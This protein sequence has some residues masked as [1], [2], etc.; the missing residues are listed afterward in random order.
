MILLY[1]PFICIL[2]SVNKKSNKIYKVLILNKSLFPNNLTPW[3]DISYNN[4]HFIWRE[5]LYYL[6]P[7]IFII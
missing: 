5:A 1:E 4:S 2:N 6:I 3:N 7:G